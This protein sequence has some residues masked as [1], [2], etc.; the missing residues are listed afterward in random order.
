MVHEHFRTFGRWLICSPGLVCGCFSRPAQGNGSGYNDSGVR[1]SGRPGYAEGVVRMR[2]MLI[3]GILGLGILISCHDRDIPPAVVEQD[4]SGQ[5]RSLKNEKLPAIPIPTPY[6]SSRRRFEFE[7]VPGEAPEPEPA[8]TPDQ[9]GRQFKTYEVNG[10]SEDERFVYGKIRINGEGGSG[11]LTTDGGGRISVRVYL[12]QDSGIVGRDSLGGRYRLEI[13]PEDSEEIDGGGWTV[14]P[15]LD[16]L[17]GQF[18]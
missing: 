3:L 6:S 16:P 5:A 9:K 8:A 17:G 18:H 4:G 10:W 1:D 15:G 7:G 11:V 13:E 14:D 2:R 12:T